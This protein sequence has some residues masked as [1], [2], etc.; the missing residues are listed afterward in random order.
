MHMLK[1]APAINRD[2]L[3]TNHAM[4][5]VVAISGLLLELHKNVVDILSCFELRLE[6]HV[7]VAVLRVGSWSDQVFLWHDI[8][9][10]LVQSGYAKFA[11][12]ALKNDI[13]FSWAI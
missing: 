2:V 7:A 12:L 5:F 10:I 9:R 1:E 3:W 11:N 8:C 4:T 6:K 13:V